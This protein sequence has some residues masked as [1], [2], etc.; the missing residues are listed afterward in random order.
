[1]N[2]LH[3]VPVSFVHT[4][5]SLIG[6]VQKIKAENLTACTAIMVARHSKGKTALAEHHG[7]ALLTNSVCTLQNALR[8]FSPHSVPMPLSL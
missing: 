1:M 3:L 4:Q 7:S 5:L 2:R 8:P 6:I